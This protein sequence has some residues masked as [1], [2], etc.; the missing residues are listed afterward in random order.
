MGRVTGS[1]EAIRPTISLDLR[2]SMANEDTNVLSIP[3]AANYLASGMIRSSLL[4]SG[5]EGSFFSHLVNNAP[6]MAATNIST[7][8]STMD[9][10]IY[11]DKHAEDARYLAA[12]ISAIAD[13]S[14]RKLRLTSVQNKAQVPAGQDWIFWLTQEGLPQNIQA[15]NIFRYGSGKE[16]PAKSWLV[17]GNG[18]LPENSIA[19]YKHTGTKSLATNGRVENKTA[20][21]ASG[22]DND[23]AA[24][25]SGIIWKN[26]YGDPILTVDETIGGNKKLATNKAGEQT[27]N[28][29]KDYTDNHQDNFN[30]V[31]T[32]YCRINPG[33]TELPWS[34]AF[35]KML[36]PLILKDTTITNIEKLQ[37]IHDRRAVDVAEVMPLVV[38]NTY[39]TAQ[40]AFNTI[41]LNKL[42]WLL[43]FLLFAAERIIA[44][45]GSKFNK[46][47]TSDL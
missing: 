23:R 8:T 30:R 42:V 37:R 16:I 15:K 13:F 39:K 27:G 18:P 3:V 12:A 10:A 43:A 2:W 5:L 20:S 21:P 29:A 28:A 34:P 25:A 32:F 38:R 7:D 45:N 35:P 41:S 26:G 44:L 6:Q 19:I 47:K 40:T 11:S 17:A 9:I 4:N 46:R 22:V 24:D 14:Q 33:W 1:P 31:Y 36:L